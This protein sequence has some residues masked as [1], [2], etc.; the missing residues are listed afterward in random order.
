MV[1]G[2]CM[3][4]DTLGALII[5]IG[6]LERGS[7]KGVYKGSIVEF[8]NIGALLI[9]IIIEA[10]MILASTGLCNATK[11]TLQRARSDAARALEV[12][13]LQRTCRFPQPRFRV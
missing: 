2:L 9:R 3:F 5:R 7:F 13:A 1:S 11:R 12:R 10:P 8:Y 6:F 4:A